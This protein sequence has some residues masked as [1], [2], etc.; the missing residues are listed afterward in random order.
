MRTGH[1]ILVVKLPRER[2]MDKP[3]LRPGEEISLGDTIFQ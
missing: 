3:R 2:P 1:K